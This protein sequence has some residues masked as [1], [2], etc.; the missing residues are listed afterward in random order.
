MSLLNFCLYVLHT[1]FYQKTILWSARNSIG[2]SAS[3]GIKWDSYEMI[4]FH[5][6]VF[7]SK[8]T[9]LRTFWFFNGMKFQEKTANFLNACTKHVDSKWWQPED[10][11]GESQMLVSFQ[12]FLHYTSIVYI[13]IHANF[14]LNKKIQYYLTLC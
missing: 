10:I 12:F 7:Q 2:K 3:F 4:S 9:L 8:C 6:E 14:Y 11:T 13:I 1:R 5:V